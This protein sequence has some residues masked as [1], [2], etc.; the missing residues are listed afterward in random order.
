MKLFSI[1]GNKSNMDIYENGH[2]YDL[3]RVIYNY[4]YLCVEF[5]SVCGVINIF[6]SNLYKKYSDE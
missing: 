6:W 4:R 1:I 3:K 2:R 5:A